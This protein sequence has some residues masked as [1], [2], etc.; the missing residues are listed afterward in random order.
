MRLSPGFFFVGG[1]PCAP[2]RSSAA[3]G[4]KMGLKAFLFFEATRRGYQPQA[5]PSHIPRGCPLLPKQI[6]VCA[7]PV[8]HKLITINAIDQKPVRL[9]VALL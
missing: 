1:I 8:K 2:G 4:L 7:C 5:P 9:Y 3:E 6:G